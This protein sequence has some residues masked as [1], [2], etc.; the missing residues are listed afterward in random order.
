MRVLVAGAGY[1]GATLARELAAAGHRVHALRRRPEPLGEGIT[2]IAADL[3]DATAP[4]ALPA[5]LDTLVY[6][7]AP[8]GS[9]DAAYERAY[10]VGLERVLEEAARQRATLRRALFT[11]STAVYAQDDGGVVDESSE[12]SASAAGTARF[13][14]AGE[15]VIAALGEGRGVSLRLAGIYGPGRD[16]TVRMVKDGTAR[17]TAPSPIGNRIH[18]DDCAGA[19]AHLLAL[20]A[21]A[22]VYVGVDDAPAPLDEVYRWLARELGVA[23]PPAGP[24]DARGR[25]STRK[26][27]SNRRLRASGYALRYPTYRE[28]YRALIDALG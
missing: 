22:P 17:I 6:S 8:D 9:S 13:L 20:E 12:V 10:V 26:R 4:L 25:A 23:E 28:G 19:I 11:S 24:A 5:D 1:V 16:R 27:C 7:V 15:R 18:R 3:F 14:L 2:T 21:P